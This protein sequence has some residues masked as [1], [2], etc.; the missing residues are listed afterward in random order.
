[1]AEPSTDPRDLSTPEARYMAA[2]GRDLPP[3][4]DNARAEL[5]ELLER[6]RQLAEQFYGP[7]AA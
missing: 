6:G 2:T 4:D 5:D 3:F 7:Q 1:M